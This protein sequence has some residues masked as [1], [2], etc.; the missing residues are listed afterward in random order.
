[1]KR[2]TV[3]LFTAEPV[4]LLFVVT[5]PDEREPDKYVLSTFIDQR[6]IAR[7]AVTLEESNQ[8]VALADA[9]RPLMY[10]AWQDD[11]GIQ[12][13]LYA[14][15]ADESESWKGAEGLEA[16]FLGAVVRATEFRVHPNSLYDEGVDHFSAI[17][18]GKTVEPI[19]QMMKRLA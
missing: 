12:G 5:D 19:E 1:M 2:E 13:Y 18:I 9:T 6:R 8:I 14:L 3:T 17:L 16:V 10:I 11:P 15:T 4:Q 7:R